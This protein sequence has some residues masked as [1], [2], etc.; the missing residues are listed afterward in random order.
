MTWQIAITLQV[1][2]SA[3]MTLFTRHITLSNKRVFIGV[4]VGSYFA[5]AVCGFIF[6]IISH[7]GLPVFPSPT[8]WLF[9]IIE[10]L[11]I[12]AAWLVQYKLISSLGAANAITISTLNTVG[13]AS[14]GILFLGESISM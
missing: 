5:V 3:L 4:G 6:A 7:S 13:A 8:A 2:V 9:I 1:F 11:C 14:L 12:P 10:G